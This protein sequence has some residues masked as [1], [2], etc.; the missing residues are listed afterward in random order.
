MSETT[1]RPPFFERL[2]AGLEEAI[3]FTEGKELNLRTTVVPEAPP[4][5]IA[6]DVV[7]LR[8]R[9]GMSQGFFAQLLNVSAKTVQSW[10]QG[11]RL[12]SQAALR[13]LQMFDKETV[14]AC[15]VAGLQP[16]LT[17]SQPRRTKRRGK[18]DK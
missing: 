10:E 13:L 11:E 3:Q 1:K 12:P 16:V 14:A 5:M 17:R 7:R 8:K 9:L 18:P 15:Q 4:P 6:A 2:K